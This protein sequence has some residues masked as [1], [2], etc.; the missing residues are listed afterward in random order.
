VSKVQKF[1]LPIV[2]S[3]FLSESATE[4]SERL[5]AVKALV[6]EVFTLTKA[7]LGDE[8]ARKLFAKMSHRR[9]GRRALD[10]VNA[11]LLGFYDDLVASSPQKAKSAPRRI[12]ERL[13]RMGVT[14][15]GLSPEAIIKK[16]NRLVGARR[17]SEIK[18]LKELEGM[19][20]AGIMLVDFLDPAIEN[21]KR[22]VS[23]HRGA[24]GQ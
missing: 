18:A 15:Y 6:V 12:A 24:D 16:V 11:E 23:G 1:G 22:R 2:P 9:K 8:E 14:K 20:S 7:H 3:P 21:L 17:K 5:A 13:D 10:S 4:R 19:R